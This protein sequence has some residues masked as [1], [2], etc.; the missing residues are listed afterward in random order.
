VIEII[1]NRHVHVASMSVR[2]MT[3]NVKRCLNLGSYNY[4]GFGDDWSISCANQVLPE[5]NS[6]PMSMC[7]SRADLGTTRLH[8]ELEKKVAKFVG[9]F[10]GLLRPSLHAPS[11]D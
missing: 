8:D 2:L 3:G 10:Q 6:W 7:S 9:M 11:S 4:L 1:I 5:V